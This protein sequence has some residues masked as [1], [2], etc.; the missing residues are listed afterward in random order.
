MEALKLLIADGTEDFRI[1]LADALRGSYR[2]RECSD[3]IQALELLRSFRPDLLVVDLMLPGLDGIS[4]LQ[5]AAEMESRPMV[6][7]TTRFQSEYVIDTVSK[8]GVGYLMIKPCDIRSTVS[9]IQDLRQRLNPPAVTR[10]DPG[11]FVSN[12]L[13]LLGVATNLRGYL[14]LREAIPMIARDRKQ[15]ITK[16]LY[17]RIAKQ[18]DCET[19]CVE[20]SIRSAIGSAWKRRDD[21][22]WRGY[23]SPEANGQIKKP[24]NGKFITRLAMCPELTEEG[25]NP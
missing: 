5:E 8:L 2:I 24:S 16:E 23:F 25:T 1:A 12:L 4:L 13:L 20:R 9:R 6:L 11:V 18:F 7:A 21:R 10:P 22:I 15:S 17:P 19:A 14:Y 3:G